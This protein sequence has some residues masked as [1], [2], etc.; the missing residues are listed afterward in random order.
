MTG[1]IS[2]EGDSR[3]RREEV[4]MMRTEGGERGFG[5]FALDAEDG[6]GWFGGFHGEVGMRSWGT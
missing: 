1:K 5:G 6:V 4:G 2:A 3:P